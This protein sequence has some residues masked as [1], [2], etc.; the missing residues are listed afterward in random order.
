M[1]TAVWKILIKFPN[2]PFKLVKPADWERQASYLWFG[3]THGSMCVTCSQVHVQN[4]S[5]VVEQEQREG[6]A[7]TRPSLTAAFLT[8]SRFGSLNFMK[9]SSKKAWKYTPKRWNISSR[10][11]TRITII[12][13]IYSSLPK[14]GVCVRFL[15]KMQLKGRYGRKVLLM[16]LIVFQKL[17]NFRLKHPLKH[18][19]GV[20]TWV[21]LLLFEGQAAVHERWSTDW[22]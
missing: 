15:T 11:G 18:F 10:R 5:V 19:S 12:S 9:S 13:K 17:T 4:N 7:A 16:T 20:Q 1:L 8:Q 14:P 2:W 3:Y 6:H 21:L 22:Y